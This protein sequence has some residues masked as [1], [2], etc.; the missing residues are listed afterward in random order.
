MNINQLIR[1][2]EV[3][4]SE[5]G[6]EDKEI[7][8]HST[9]GFVDLVSIWTDKDAP[10]VIIEIAWEEDTEFEENFKQKLGEV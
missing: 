4:R 2:L 3:I 9:E 8:V 7:L 6:G 10:A 1:K 5:L